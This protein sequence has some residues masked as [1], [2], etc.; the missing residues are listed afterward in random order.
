MTGLILDSTI[1]IPPQGPAFGPAGVAIV[2]QS[3]CAVGNVHYRSVGRPLLRVC[4]GEV[5]GDARSNQLI[6]FTRFLDKALPLEYRDLAAATPDQAR[7]F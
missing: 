1:A 6:T 7:A 3:E 2:P 4:F 5:K